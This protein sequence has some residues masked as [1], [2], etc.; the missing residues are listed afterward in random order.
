MNESAIR[1]YFPH[2]RIQCDAADNYD[3]E[4]WAD[5]L[6]ISTRLSFPQL[7]A[8]AISELEDLPFTDFPAIQRICLAQQHDIATWLKP[9]YVELCKREAPLAF[10]EAEKIGMETAFLLGNARERTRQHASDM[11]LGVNVSIF[12]CE[13]WRIV[14]EIFEVRM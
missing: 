2:C 12:D 9:A 4:D 11:G 8:R 14:E 13:I 1:Q 10:F 7:R 6:S 3:E 5:L